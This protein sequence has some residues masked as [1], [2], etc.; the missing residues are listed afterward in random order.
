MAGAENAVAAA[1]AAAIANVIAANAPEG[2][3]GGQ[4]PGGNANGATDLQTQLAEA[5]AKIALLEAKEKLGELKVTSKNHLPKPPA[6]DGKSKFRLWRLK[7]E[8]YLSAD[9]AEKRLWGV[10]AIN[11]LADNVLNHILTQLVA[12]HSVDPHSALDPDILTYDWL[13]QTIE[14]GAFGPRQTNYGVRKLLVNLKQT[15]DIGEHVRIF[16]EHAAKAT[17]VIDPATKCYFFLES[18]HSEVASELDID[19][20]SKKEWTDWTLLR[21]TALARAPNLDRLRRKA[22]IK[23]D[24]KSAAKPAATKRTFESSK[25]EAS[26][27][28]SKDNTQGAEKKKSRVFVPGLDFRKKPELRAEYKGLCFLCKSPD[29]EVRDCPLNKNKGKN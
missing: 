6:Y 22:G 18:L 4:N 20:S 17:A 5:Q 26:G 21:Q 9:G 14:E 24:T 10:H 11:Y 16:D 23:T 19:A 7:L 29:H 13:V 25:G 2:G 3:A 27:S 28:G 12:Q 1:A 8:G 15:T